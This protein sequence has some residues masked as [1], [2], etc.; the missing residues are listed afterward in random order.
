M[1]TTHER[2]RYLSAS[3]TFALAKARTAELTAE[4]EQ[5]RVARAVARRPR[6]GVAW[7]A[8]VVTALRDSL[9][10]RATGRGELC[11]TC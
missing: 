9:A 6:R 7:P 4:A 2:D 11:P 1:T 5:A 10:S 3:M 8:R